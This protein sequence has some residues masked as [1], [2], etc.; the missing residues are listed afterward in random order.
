MKLY[1]FHGRTPEGEEL[2]EIVEEHD[3]SETLREIGLHKCRK[4]GIENAAW[5]STTE[6]WQ[7]LVADGTVHYYIR[8]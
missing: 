7:E 5:I 6:S 3:D 1:E 8:P 4:R 2:A